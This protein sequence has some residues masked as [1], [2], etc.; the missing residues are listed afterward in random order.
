[1]KIKIQESDSPEVKQAKQA[2]IDLYNDVMED[3]GKK[4]KSAEEKS[5][6]EEDVDKKA[7]SVIEGFKVK[8]GDKE[9]LLTD[10][11]K[12]LDEAM[13]KLSAKVANQ[14]KADSEKP[15]SFKEAFAKEYKAKEA[16]IKAAINGNQKEAIVLDVKAAVTIGDFNTIGGVGSDSAY[17]LT[18]NTGIISTIRKRMLMYLQNVSTGTMTGDRAMWI[19]ELDEQGE[20]IFIGEGDP[21]TQLSV[22]YEERD[23]KAKKIPVYGK[24]TTEMMADLPQLISYVQN[25]LIK[26][27]E[28]K[29]ENQ[30]FTGD[31]TGNNLA[32]LEGYATAFTGS[33]LAGTIE[34]ANVF[35]V[36]NAAILQVQKAFG[37]AT[38][39][40]INPSFTA[41]MV[42]I[43]SQ[44]GEY[45]HPL[46]SLFVVDA[47]GFMRFRGVSLIETNALDGTGIDFIGGDLSV[48]N[49]RQRQGVTVQIGLDG[50]DFTNNVK[51]IL[52]EERLVQFVSANDT[53]VLVKGDF[54]SAK[55][56]LETT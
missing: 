39:F 13:A 49:V 29:K 11:I 35:D 32:G 54:A 3:A 42:S 36:L 22:R 31:D 14:E 52:V 41:Q 19:E 6:T 46:A 40:W 27:L 51:T 48:I 15:L 12:E 7:K 26:R 1:M 9:V 30:L 18:Y 53:Q 25:N 37:T 50:N 47:N 44:T 20:P 5:L 28:I 21:K 10:F 34:F 17:S 16:E 38:G 43:K 2:L 24:V 4:F 56:I 8:D 23:K 45:T 55:A 33:D